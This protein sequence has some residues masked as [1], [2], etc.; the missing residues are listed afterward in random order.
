MAHPAKF[1]ETVRDAIGRAA[2]RRAL[3]RLDAAARRVALPA[4][5]A[6]VK[7]RLREFAA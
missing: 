6:A 2:E 5:V 4:D 3:S 7:A 1:P